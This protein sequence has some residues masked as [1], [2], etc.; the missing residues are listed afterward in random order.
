MTGDIGINTFDVV[1]QPVMPKNVVTEFKV[2]TVT[3][4]KLTVTNN[5]T[6]L[7]SSEMMKTITEKV[8]AA[9]VTLE[10]AVLTSSTTT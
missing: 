7:A 1:S 3:G 10:K 2:D 6:V 9:D 4:T 8:K 5:P